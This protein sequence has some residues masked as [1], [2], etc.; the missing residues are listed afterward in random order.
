MLGSVSL[1][2][3]STNSTLPSNRAVL[4][5]FSEKARDEIVI[6]RARIEEDKIAF[7][8]YENALG[9]AEEAND[10]SEVQIT[11]LRSEVGQLRI[12]L[13]KDRDALALKEKEAVE[14]EKALAKMT[15]KKNFF[16]TLFKAS[17]V[18]T[19]I[20]VA[21]AATVILTE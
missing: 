12:A 15:K 18:T 5:A 21:V 3:T 10:L 14:Y 8:S 2:Q 17:A 1:S 4:I 19:V 7:E 9:K 16:K 20:F 13:G 11:L 6:L